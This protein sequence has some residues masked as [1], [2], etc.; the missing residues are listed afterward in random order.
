MDY[1][2]DSQG[3]TSSQ[4][5]S[6]ADV[7]ATREIT[8]TEYRGLR[9][10][11]CKKMD[12]RASFIVTSVTTSIVALGVGT[13]RESGPIL[14]L[15]PIIA[16]LFGMLIIIHERQIKETSEYI[17]DKIEL[18]LSE[19]YPNSMGWH[20]TKGEMIKLQGRLPAFYLPLILIM[21]IP[22]AAGFALAWSFRNPLGL[23]APLAAAGLVLIIVY[24]IQYRLVVN[25][26]PFPSWPRK[27]RKV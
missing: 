15:T 21:A 23:T 9:D 4:I 10:E 14:L 2:V 20:L 17:C 18:P 12:H 6:S 19:V 11:I 1:C 5:N 8:L 22:S 25:R 26:R 7:E 13:E 24:T 16:A 3:R 27:S